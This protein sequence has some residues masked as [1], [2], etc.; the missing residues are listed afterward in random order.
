MDA[1]D[2]EIMHLLVKI[3]FGMSLLILVACQPDSPTGALRIDTVPPDVPL[4]IDGNFV[5]NSPS[6]AGQYFAIEISEGQHIVSALVDVDKEKQLYVEK[7]IFVA[8]D[9]LQTITLKLEERLTPFG[10]EEIKRRETEAAEKKRLEEIEL[11]RREVIAQERKKKEAERALELKIANKPFADILKSNPIKSGRKYHKNNFK[12][13]A[14]GCNITVAKYYPNHHF[15]V[16]ATVNA[17]NLNPENISIGR[18]WESKIMKYSGVEY[19]FNCKGGNDCIQVKAPGG[20]AKEAEEEYINVSIDDKHL[21]E[22]IASAVK[23][24]TK[25]C[26]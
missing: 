5:G 17:K 3:I 10:V 20:T 18:Q 15:T 9:T 23:E 6:G 13:T 22:P 25:N 26:Q 1:K 14:E 21:A 7:N 8:A 24:I 19:K 2:R 4:T 12:Y 16:T 11:K